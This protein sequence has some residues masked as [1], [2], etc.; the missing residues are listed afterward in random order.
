MRVLITGGAGCLGSNLVEHWLAGG[1]DVLVIDNFATGKAGA[2][3]PSP[4]VR[5]IEGTI[6]DRD[7][8]ESAYAEFRPTHIVHSAASYKDPND[9]REDVAT[10]V[11]GTIHVVEAARVH[12]VA[13]FVNFQTV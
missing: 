5:L 6:A 1:H 2:L 7:L 4:Q 8:V 11:L 3:P 10:N 13:R 12:G 9:W